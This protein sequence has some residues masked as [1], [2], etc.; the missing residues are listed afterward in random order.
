M[1]MPA[2]AAVIQK[3]GV[4]SIDSLTDPQ[5]DE[6]VQ[7]LREDLPGAV[8]FIDEACQLGVQEGSFAYLSKSPEDMASKQGWSDWSVV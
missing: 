6:V 7:V 3:L 4:E 8:D 1:T 2:T 5:L